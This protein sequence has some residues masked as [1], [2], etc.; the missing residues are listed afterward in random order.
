MHRG[1]FYGPYGGPFPPPGFSAYG[2]YYHGDNSH[3]CSVGSATNS[4]DPKSKASRLF[5]G[6]LNTG[7]VTRRDIERLFVPYGRITGISLHKGFGFVQFTSEFNARRAKEAEN[8]R[9]VAKQPIDIYVA[10]EPDAGRPKGF[11]RIDYGSGAVGEKIAGTSCSMR[12]VQHDPVSGDEPASWK[13][14]SCGEKALSA[15][16]LMKHSAEAHQNK[17]Y[18]EVTNEK[19]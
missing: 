5:I 4:N 18:E 8:N 19:P 2:A 7:Y 6:N 12:Q 16:E 11:K 3:L 14:A 1:A 13:C 17:I 15:W 10:S 9:I